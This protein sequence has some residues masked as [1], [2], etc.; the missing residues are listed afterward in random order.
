ML[1]FISHNFIFP[2]YI[3]FWVHTIES[4]KQATFKW[5]FFNIFDP[6]EIWINI[7]YDKFNKIIHLWFLR[8]IMLKKISLSRFEFLFILS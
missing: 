7:E 1:N 6:L 4:L 3:K 5:F 8:D 2:Q